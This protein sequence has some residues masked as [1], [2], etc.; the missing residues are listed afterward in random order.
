ML[1]SG[2][3]YTGYLRVY[4]I[5]LFDNGTYSINPNFWRHPY[6]GTR[7]QGMDYGHGYLWYL[8]DTYEPNPTIEIAQFELHDDGTMPVK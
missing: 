3:L 1:V 2:G 5:Q 6:L 7:T 8:Y 4:E